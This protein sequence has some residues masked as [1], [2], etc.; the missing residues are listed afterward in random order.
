[1]NLIEKTG[2]ASQDFQEND[3]KLRIDGLR[4]AYGSVHAL[5]DIFIDVPAGE[6]LTLLGPSGSGKTT[7]LMALAGLVAPDGG[8]LWIDGRLST[9]TP[10]SERGIG[11]V[12]QNY[13]L[14]PHLTIYENIAFPL[15]MRRVPKAEIDRRVAKMLDIVQL[16]HV[17]ERLPIE[18]SGGQQQRIAV[19]RCAVYEPSVIFMDEPL[20][21][22]D[23]RLRDQ[24]QL[25]I[26]RLHVELG[27]TILYVT[28]DQEEAMAMS[29]RICRM[30]EGRVEQIG[31]PDE[32]YFRP[33]TMF[34]AEF[35]GDSNI[36]RAEIVER[37]TAKTTL[38]NSDGTVFHA[39]GLEF[40]P[41]DGRQV[42]VLTRPEQIRILSRDEAAENVLE[43]TV[44]R[45]IVSG[46][47]TRYH[48]R[49]A[50]GT[51]VK[52][53]QLTTGPDGR[54]APGDKVRLGWSLDSNVLLPSQSAPL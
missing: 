20:G 45:A 21:A 22:L 49:L 38:R 13:A 12:F 36:F 54:S 34:A 37:G 30:N 26:K 32:L 1:M 27:I 18:L 15:R 7:L 9:Y 51:V 2:K 46:P 50:D 47:M 43:A 52:V 31:T 14:F 35:L 53:I 33:K 19:A 5:R 23:K 42:S 11:F 17:A 24:M 28:H 25:E 3:L 29:D 16:P 6:F 48:T 40:Q 4:K 10:P 8:R 44:E 41:E 39:G